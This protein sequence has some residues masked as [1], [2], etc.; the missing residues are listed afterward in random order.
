MEF[1]IKK[2]LLKKN[3]KAFVDEFK[4]YV[5]YDLCQDDE[6]VFGCFISSEKNIFECFLIEEAMFAPYKH[7]MLSLGYIDTGEIE[8][9]YDTEETTIQELLSQLNSMLQVIIN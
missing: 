7:C 8:Y 6:G 4:Y 5:A 3:I 1:E 9:W 2:Q